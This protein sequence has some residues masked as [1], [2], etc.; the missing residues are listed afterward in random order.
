MT[1]G[2]VEKGSAYHF[3]AVIYSE[4][5]S[6]ENRRVFGLCGRDLKPSVRVGGRD[7]RGYGRT[8]FEGKT[9]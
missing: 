4:Y 5:G 6:S 1:V 7:A 2:A 3:G 8:D 9:S